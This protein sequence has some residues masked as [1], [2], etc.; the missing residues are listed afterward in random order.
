MYHVSDWRCQ[1]EKAH[2]LKLIDLHSREDSLYI[3]KYN[4]EHMWKNGISLTT[5]LRLDLTYI[6]YQPFHHDHQSNCNFGSTSVCIIIHFVFM[7]EITCLKYE[8]SA[9][10][11]KLIIFL[12]FSVCLSNSLSLFPNILYDV[13]QFFMALYGPQLTY[14]TQ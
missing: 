14:S 12:L 10:F 1:N 3:K 11:S 4:V 5:I 8:I 2:V 6:M 13:R 9:L 7:S